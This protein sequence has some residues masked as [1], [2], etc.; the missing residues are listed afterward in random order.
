MVNGSV[1]A[2]VQI[3]S[4]NAVHQQLMEHGFGEYSEEDYM[5]RVSCASRFA[6]ELVS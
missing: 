2:F 4:K 6:I 1:S 5:S 3:D